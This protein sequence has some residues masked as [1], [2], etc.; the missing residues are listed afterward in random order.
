MAKRSV[1]KIDSFRRRSVRRQAAGLGLTVAI[2]E[3]TYDFINWS[4][5]GMMLLGKAGA[6]ASGDQVFAAL[7][8]EG[9]EPAYFTAR[10]VHVN[11]R[12]GEAGLAFTDSALDAMLGELLK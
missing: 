7:H 12:S 5:G 11:P 3:E 1:L 2:G 8:R 10:V 6:L 4:R 9:D